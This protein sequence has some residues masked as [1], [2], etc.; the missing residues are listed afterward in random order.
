MKKVFTKIAA[1]GG[2]TQLTDMISTK[3]S[4]PIISLLLGQIYLSGCTTANAPFEND[5]GIVGA[6]YVV[7]NKPEQNSVIG[8]G[9]KS[10]GTFVTLGEYPTGGK[11]TGDLEVPGLSPRDDSHPL[12]DGQDPLISAY[13]IE[14]TQDGKFVLVSNP[15]DG[16]ISSMKVN[17]DNSLTHVSTVKS[18]GAFPISIT[19]SSNAVFV[20]NIGA[21][22]FKGRL[23]GFTI[24][25]GGNLEPIEGSVRKLARFGGRPSSVKFTPSGKHLLVTH[26]LSGVI[27]VYSFEDGALS[28]KPVST[29]DSPQLDGTRSLANPVGF[30]FIDKRNGE[31]IAV[32]SEAR[33]FAPALQLPKRAGQFFFQTSSLS[34]YKVTDDGQISLVTAD[35]LTGMAREGG[36]RTNCWIGLSAD[37]KY[38]Y[39][40]NAL[41]SSISSYVIGADGSATLLEEVAYKTSKYTFLRDISRSQDG[42]YF[43][44]L[45]GFGGK[46]SVL[47]IQPNGAL[48]EV[49]VLDGG[50]PE[51]G[52]FGILA[53]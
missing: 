33:F 39:G 41:D 40:V 21:G 4:F 20:A 6:A 18:G 7:T 50:V 51:V 11:G 44:Q 37:G 15:G 2:L 53:M 45:H 25:A 36:Q 14:K 49:V 24:D 9:R 19:T 34:T 30:D 10:D 8:F 5:T 31:S 3:F 17:N 52:A 35:A 1:A 47:E 26:I 32:V 42:K 43:Y 16:T 29:V 38:A 27:A 48:V 13:A 46:V 23:A 28:R 12:S 22:N